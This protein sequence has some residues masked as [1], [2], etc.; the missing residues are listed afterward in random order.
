M[1]LHECDSAKKGPV[2][3]ELSRSLTAKALHA[4]TNIDCLSI[5]ACHRHNHGS[6]DID[7]KP[8][9]PIGCGDY[10]YIEL[11]CMDHYEVDV[12]KHDG[13]VRGLAVATETD[14]NGEYLIIQLDKDQRESIRVDQIK[15][16]IV[17]S[18]PRRFDERTF[19][20]LVDPS[21]RP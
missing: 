7:A 15:Q 8:Y 13:T 14:D 20:P 2:R 17:R 10:E 9:I 16:I 21:Q 5:I 1:L 4:R 12:I 6:N 18:E 19:E 11:A 3:L